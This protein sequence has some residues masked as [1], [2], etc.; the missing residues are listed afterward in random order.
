MKRLAIFDLDGTLLN[1]IADLGEA[2]NYALK[3]NRLPTHRIEKY[4]LM[5]GNGVRALI[6]RAL[7]ENARKESTVNRVLADFKFYYGNHLIT[8]TTPYPVL[9]ELLESLVRSHFLIAVASN[10]YQAATRALVNHFFPNIPFVAVE[11][12]R[13]DRPTKPDPAIVDDILAQANR[14]IAVT[15]GTP[16]T[17]DDVLYIGDSDVDMAT[18]RAAG[19]ESVGVTWGFRPRKELIEAGANHIVDTPPEIFSLLLQ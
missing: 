5:V 2:T 6:E 1:T 4:N 9:P 3:L 16:I 19:V 17:K 12:Q 11:G 14:A 13:P 18:A 8:H 10:K 15:S 7:P